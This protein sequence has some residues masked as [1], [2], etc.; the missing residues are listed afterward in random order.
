MQGR[1]AS[2]SGEVEAVCRLGNVAFRRGCVVC[3]HARATSGHVEAV[4]R[5]AQTGSGKTEAICRNTRIAFRHGTAACRHRKGVCR[6]REVGYRCGK[7]ESRQVIAVCRQRKAV[8]GR[9]ACRCHH[10]S[11][12]CP[13]QS[14]TKG[15]CDVEKRSML[16]RVPQRTQGRFTSE[17]SYQE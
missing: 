12:E 9:M 1:I 3:R 8:R 13:A 2:I 7:A 4:F 15:L 17:F 5:H 16:R 10:L 6:N 14:L 11:V